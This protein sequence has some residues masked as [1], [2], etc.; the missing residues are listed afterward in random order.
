VGQPNLDEAVRRALEN[1][2]TMAGVACLLVALDDTFVRPIPTTMKAVGLFHAAANPLITPQLQ[3]EVTHRLSNAAN[4]WNAVAVGATGHP[5]LALKAA[6][7]QAA[8]EGA[9]ADCAKQDRDCRVI[10]IG[11]FAVEPL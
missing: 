9:L 11:P 3:D 7:E 4:G 6:S 10:A 5:G 2:G 8:V 1:C